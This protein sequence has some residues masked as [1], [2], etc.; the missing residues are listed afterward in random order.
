[1][2][3]KKIFLEKYS[4]Q[5][6]FSDSQLKWDDLA[7]IYDDYVGEKAKLD[8][9]RKELEEYL[10]D[11]MDVSYHSIRGRVKDPEHLLE[12]IIRKRGREQS[13][14]YREINGRNYKNII[15][16]MIGIRIL[17]LAKEDW[18]D[19]FKALINCFPDK[20]DG[21]IYMAEPPVAYTRYGDR[22]IFG[23][24]IRK[25]HSNKGYRSQHYIVYF[26]GYYCE[27]QV[28]TLMEEVYGEFDHKVKYPYREDNKFLLRYTKT[29]SQLLGAADEI[30]ST[31]FQM[32]E[33]GWDECNQ[34]FEEDSYADWM[35]TSQKRE[36]QREKKNRIPEIK[37]GEKIE[38]DTYAKDMIMRR[39]ADHE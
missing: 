26:K 14:K 36:V 8:K 7:E 38:A 21:E 25:E 24:L 6:T 27:I 13:S 17:V 1:M 11:Q 32:K 29:V 37:T 3:D 34:Y 28:R 33:K 30:L 19:V 2:L 20:K 39:R 16:D 31:C 4:L 10:K 35:K 22:D 23:D 18:R 12:K 15:H 5:K 9:C